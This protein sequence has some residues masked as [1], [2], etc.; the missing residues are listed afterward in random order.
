MLFINIDD[1]CSV[2]FECAGLNHIPHTPNEDR[3]CW[4]ENVL[5]ILRDT[6]ITKSE[7]VTC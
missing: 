4:K 6:S 5:W 2:A 3:D 7:A 1:S